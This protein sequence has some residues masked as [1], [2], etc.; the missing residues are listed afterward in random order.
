VRTIATLAITIAAGS[1]AGQILRRLAFQLQQAASGVPDKV[2]TGASTVL[3][4]DNA[5]AN[6]IASVQITGGPYQSALFFA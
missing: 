6:G 5:P 4:I 1:D 3:T 2:P